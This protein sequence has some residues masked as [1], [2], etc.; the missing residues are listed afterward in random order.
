MSEREAD[1]G[2]EEKKTESPRRLSKGLDQVES[3][4]EFEDDPE[5]FGND[6]ELAPLTEELKEVFGDKQFQTEEELYGFMDQ[7]GIADFPI[8]L[9]GQAL[10]VRMPTDQHNKFTS[11]IVAKF[12]RRHADWGYVTATH[13]V[14][15]ATTTNKHREPD[16]SFFGSP[17]CVLDAD[18][19]LVPYDD[20]AVPDFVIQ[21]SWRNKRGYEE[22]A[23]DEMMNDA[24]EIER[25]PASATCPRVGYL[26]KVRFKKKRTL[27]NAVKGS[28]TQDIGGLDIY[29]LPHGTT[30]EDAINARDGASKFTYVPGGPDYNISISSQ[31]LGLTS[32]QVAWNGFEIRAS[33]IFDDM[34]AYHKKR[35][36]KLLAT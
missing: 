1:R 17:R 11:N 16:V 10:Y 21:F 28:K 19:D 8:I 30:I 29:R 27:A 18:G 22:E 23:M 14:H 33:R 25:G 12:L 13:N 32:P 9:E 6:T 7:A 3:P 35:Q 4:I 31:D 26:I 5:E 34:D 24:A 20:G 36:Q 2:E 15:L